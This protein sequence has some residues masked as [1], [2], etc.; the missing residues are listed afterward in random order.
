MDDHGFSIP[1]AF[2]DAIRATLREHP[3]RWSPALDLFGA[4]EIDC[5]PCHCARHCHCFSEESE[6]C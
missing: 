4:H 1:D 6:R 5:P 2:A 3:P